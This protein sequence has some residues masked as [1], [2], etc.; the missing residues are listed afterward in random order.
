MLRVCKLRHAIFNQIVNVLLGPL[1]FGFYAYIYV[2]MLGI[3]GCMV[4]DE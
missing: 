1:G 3:L 2:G 4:G